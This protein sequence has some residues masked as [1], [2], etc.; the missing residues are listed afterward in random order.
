MYRFLW[1]GSDKMAR[2]DIAKPIDQGGL[3]L[4]GCDQ[5]V[6]AT[7]LKWFNKAQ[8]SNAAWVDFMEYNFSKLGGVRTLQKTNPK[9]YPINLHSVS[10]GTWPNVSRPQIRLPDNEVKTSGLVQYGTTQFLLTIAG[11]Y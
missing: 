6:L 4:H 11:K 2:K 9:Q 7:A 8:K 3:K 5:M 1:N 10:T